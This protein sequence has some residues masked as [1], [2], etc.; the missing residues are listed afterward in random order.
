[1]IFTVIANLIP[2]QSG[3]GEAIYWRLPRRPEKIGLLAMTAI[4][5]TQ[6]EDIQIII[7]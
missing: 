6:F 4:L 7:L 1:V 3:L 2:I 5:I